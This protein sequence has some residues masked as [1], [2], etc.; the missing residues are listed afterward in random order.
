MPA[1][2]RRFRLSFNLQVRY[3]FKMKLK[4]P[5]SSQSTV[6]RACVCA[7]L[8][9]AHE[10]PAREHPARSHED[11]PENTP[12]G[13]MRDLLESTPQAVTRTCPRTLRKES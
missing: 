1:S 13:V 2:T 9:K 11:L 4:T 7:L 8:R 10:G 12:Q 6:C 5:P 3:E